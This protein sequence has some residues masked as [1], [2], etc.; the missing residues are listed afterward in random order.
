M[1]TRTRVF[2]LAAVVFAAGAMTALVTGIP[3]GLAVSTAFVAA[4]TWA[5]GPR[6]GIVVLVAEILVSLPILSH[7]GLPG[8]PPP[9]MIL[10]PVALNN[11]L[12]PGLTFSLLSRLRRTRWWSS[13]K[14]R[15]GGLSRSRTTARSCDGCCHGSSGSGQSG[16]RSS[17]HRFLSFRVSD[18]V[19][20]SITG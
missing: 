15:F 2:L 20:S 16:T 3:S 12:M 19:P 5:C 9:A 1:S 17:S 8:G 13:W 14:D 10:V 6:V 7:I 18:P 11:A 4:A